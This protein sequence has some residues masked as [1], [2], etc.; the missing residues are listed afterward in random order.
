MEDTITTNQDLGTSTQEV[1]VNESSKTY[2]QEEVNKLLQAETDRRVNQA[3]E[4]QAKKNE[5]KVKEAQ[6]LAQMNEQEKYE[7]Q[8]KQR[9]AAIEAKEKELALAENKNE[10]SKILAEKGISLSLVDFVVA[11][12]ADTMKSN[13]DTLDKAFK[14]SVKQEVEKRLGSKTPQKNL[15]LDKTLTK[16]DFAKMSY[17]E[18]LALKQSNPDLYK[19]LAY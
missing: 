15:P 13:I 18:M 3:L 4:K 12:D 17:T 5:A 14:L 11:E 10:A 1:E 8:L 7:Y 2:T 19:Q 6:K 9:E 16:S